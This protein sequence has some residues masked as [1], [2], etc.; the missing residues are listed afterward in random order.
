[1]RKLLVLLAALASMSRIIPADDQTKTFLK[2]EHFDHDPGWDNSG[3]R[4]EASDWLVG[5][6][7]GY[8]HASV[9]TPMQYTPANLEAFRK[10]GIP[11]DIVAP[12]GGL[13]EILVNFQVPALS[14]GDINKGPFFTHGPDDFTGALQSAALVALFNGGNVPDGL[15]VVFDGFDPQTA[16]FGS[17]PVAGRV[18]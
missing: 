5:F 18:A 11:A 6:N 14:V 15:G 10:M 1:M 7:A 2:S 9:A 13:N 17:G 8:W 12:T 4:V 3:N 16:D